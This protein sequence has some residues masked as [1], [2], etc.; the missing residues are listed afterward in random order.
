MTARLVR[1]TRTTMAAICAMVVL[2]AGGTTAALATTS[3]VPTTGTITGTISDPSG[4]P[5]AGITIQLW[6]NGAVEGSLV[7]TATTWY[8]V[9]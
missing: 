8:L 7:A 3:A 2:V 9:R 6:D 5:L 4:Y 1:L